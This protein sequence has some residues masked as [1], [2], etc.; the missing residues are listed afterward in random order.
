MFKAMQKMAGAA[1]N[2]VKGMVERVAN[3]EELNAVVAAAVLIA[4]ADGNI[5]DKEKEVAFNVI[6]NHEALSA[7][8]KDRIKKSFDEYAG[9]IDADLEL[10]TGLLIGKLSV[11]KD[12]TARIKVLG[13]AKAI[14]NADGEFSD[15]EKKMVDKI[16]KATA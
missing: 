3:E 12:L 1:A 5:S 11:I 9:L 8:P 13:I 4:A 6:S 14:A 2:A 15:A 7:F 10:A 16:R